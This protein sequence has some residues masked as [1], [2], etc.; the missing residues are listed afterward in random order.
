MQQLGKLVAAE[1]QIVL[2]TATLPPSEEDELTTQTNALRREEV[3]EIVVRIA[4]QKRR[5]YK[6]G[7]IVIYGNLVAKVKKLAEQL[8]CNAYFHNAVGKA[9]ML[10]DFIDGKQQVIVATSVLGMGLRTI[11]DYAQESSRAGRDGLR[12]E[13]I[14]IRQKG[15]G[16]AC[17]N[18]QTKAEQQLVWLYVEGE[19]STTRCRRR[20]TLDKEGEEGEEDGSEDGSDGEEIDVVETEGE[21]A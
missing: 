14:I 9:S 7:K 13:A 16:R 19:E 17:D 3:E 12:S 1:T 21:E 10:A 15:D 8:A 5:Q 11:L 18:K 20:V 6:T 4:R 2:L